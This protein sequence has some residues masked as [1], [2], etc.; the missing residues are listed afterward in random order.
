MGRV[1]LGLSIGIIGT[2]L[3]PPTPATTSN[4]LV[5]A[6]GIPAELVLFQELRTTTGDTFPG[7]EVVD[8]TAAAAFP[9]EKSIVLTNG[10]AADGGLGDTDWGADG[11][12]DYTQF[13]L[14]L[15]VPEGARSLV[16]RTRFTSREMSA[17]TDNDDTASLQ[18]AYTPCQGLGC[19]SAPYD[20]ASVASALDTTSP[21]TLR[22]IRVDSL[23][24]IDLIFIVDDRENGFN[25][26][27][28]R[29]SGF[30]FSQEVSPSDNLMT[31]EL[32]PE[33]VKAAIGTYRYSKNLLSVPGTGPTF[34]LTIYY[35]STNTWSNTFGRKWSHSLE[36]KLQGLANGG[37]HIRAGDG[38]SVY[39]EPPAAGASLWKAQG[40][41]ASLAASYRSSWSGFEGSVVRNADQ[42]YTYT[43]RRNEIYRFRPDGLLTSIEDASGNAISLEHN[44]GNKVSVATDSRGNR[45]EFY[46][47]NSF[48]Q[49]ISVYYF[50]QSP[51]P[52]S[53]VFVFEYYPPS[54][55]VAGNVLWE[56]K[57][58]DEPG[59][60]I[61]GFTYDALGNLLTVTDADG[62]VT[63]DNSYVGETL[64]QSRDSQGAVDSYHYFDDALEHV[65]RLGRRSVSTF[66]SQSRLVRKSDPLG[67]T[68]RFTYDAAGNILT[69]TDPL[70]RTQIRT[71]D[72][73]A[74]LLSLTDARGGRTSWTY[75]ERNNLTG[76]IDALG[77]ATLYE[78]D[79]RDKL[80]REVDPNGDATGYRYAASGLLESFT[81]RR[82]A[83][84]S[85]TYYPTGD[86]RER[87]DPLGNVTSFVYGPLAK[88]QSLTDENGHATQ[89]SYDQ[90]GR[91]LTMTDSLGQQ[92]AYSYDVRGRKTSLTR[93]DGAITRYEYDGNGHLTRLTDALGNPFDTGYSATGHVTWQRDALGRTTQFGY[94]AA[95]HLVQVIDATGNPAG[96][97]YDAAGN[98]TG[99]VDPLGHETRL[100]YDALGRVVAETD[101]L[102]NV[103]YNA[104]DARG[105]LQFEVSGRGLR[106]DYA[107]DPVGRLVRID[108]PDH[109][110][111]HTRDPN[112]NAVLTI[113][114]G[115]ATIEREFDALDRLVRRTDQFGNAIGYEYDPAGNLVRL[116]Y[117]D[118]KA[119]EYR[120]DEL[121]RLVEVIDWA[122][123]STRYAYD[124]V[125]N[126]VQA[127]LPDGSVLERS[128]DALGRVTS[129][130]DRGT[131]GQVI[132]EARYTYDAVGQ[133][134]TAE[135]TVPL[136]P[137][138]PPEPAT[139]A[140]D[141]ANRPVARNG[142]SLEW[143][144]DG[145]L[146]A[147]SLR[148][149]RETFEYDADNRLVAAGADRFMYDED[150][151][152][153][154]AIIGG[155]IVRYTQDPNAPLSRLLE[156][157]DDQGNIVARYVYGLGLVS[158]TDAVDRLSV[159]HFDSRGSTVALTGA[160]GRI[161]DRFAYD[162]WGALVGRN[163]RTVTPFTFNGR[164]GVVDD[165]NGLYFMRARYYSPVLMRFIQKDGKVSGHLWDP[166]LLNRYSY[167]RND[168]IQAVD[169]KGDN[170]LAVI[171]IM[172][173]GAVLSVATNIAIDW[174]AGDFHPF[175]DPWGPYL[176]NNWV[177]LTVA[178]VVGSVTFGGAAGGLVAKAG[179]YAAGW[180]VRKVAAWGIQN[181]VAQYL[182]PVLGYENWTAVANDWK[183]IRDWTSGAARD[184]WDWTTT[185]YNDTKDWVEGAAEWTSN[186]ASDIADFAKDVWNW[187]T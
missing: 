157:R 121:N 68:W 132:F 151:L 101:P 141:A 79:Q 1:W 136:D 35:G 159:Y 15:R 104:Y 22:I 83:T 3:A 63:V 164:D 91:L 58:V 103:R 161:T 110:T 39:F 130:A 49:L 55:D 75:D 66:D 175:S 13:S 149:G 150:G 182:L 92:T 177:D 183:E 174:L 98:R 148:G 56:L 26:S 32:P 76:A 14:K 2:L 166:Q 179:L 82:G 134:H 38:G 158:R 118:G 128:Y 90:A 96:A 24:T 114:R 59:T 155:R 135:L 45:A 11:Q 16:F 144:A 126:V 176:E 8:A 9:E 7:T 17:G 140:Y 109:T 139:F 36:W 34:D 62:T 133:R 108:R 171:G 125:G 31:S 106:T 10:L 54:Q 57:N 100:D 25:D 70:G 170:P 99:V 97:S 181:L 111:Q 122:G 165:G 23:D 89:Y 77:F 123:R 178:A 168:P 4:E 65:D 154:E 156:E 143:D 113:G 153:I 72:S 53:R 48:Q 147:G 41:A 184:T 172:A 67:S 142:E 138:N 60:G 119:V 186:A 107:Y 95:D 5:A 185:A 129:V 12:R 93:A 180:V 44:A 87:T 21:G 84:T 112:G 37:L 28:I 47:I 6:L 46:Y 131:D 61:T 160:D 81:D 40:G 124:Q 30:H 27:A 71:Y 19:I 117:S 187:A 85:F 33:D 127:A 64:V 146:V 52:S 88:V 152:R 120:Y 173:A 94:D 74:N 29:I 145:N 137:T 51:E 43:T 78:F 18:L 20:L 80:L 50:T 105:K 167:G 169:P 69:Q 116:T 86:L 162:P 42:S 73:R 115:G 102:G 163:G